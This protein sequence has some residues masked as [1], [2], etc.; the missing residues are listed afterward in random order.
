[1]GKARRK[2]LN[3]ATYSSPGKYLKAYSQGGLVD[4]TGLAMVHGTPDAPESFLNAQDTVLLS[5]LRDALRAMPTIAVPLLAGLRGP[6]DSGAGQTMMQV[7]D[8]TVNVD[9]ID[10]EQD[11]EVLARRVGEAI[12]NGAQRA[13]APA[14][15]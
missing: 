14:W 4:Y 13:A 11:L 1:M 9:R 10:D 8:I 15:P 7:G 3:V 5:Q 6:V 2:A 12:L